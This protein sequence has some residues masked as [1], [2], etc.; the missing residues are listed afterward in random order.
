MQFSINGK[1]FP[2]SNISHANML[3]LIKTDDEESNDTAAAIVDK[4]D[5]LI[6]S[7]RE[8]VHTNDASLGMFNGH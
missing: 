1:I 6:D 3:L 4:L 2:V 7:S 5:T 8:T